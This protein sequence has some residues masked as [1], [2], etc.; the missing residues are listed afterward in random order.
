MSTTVAL[1]KKIVSTFHHRIS[2]WI[3]PVMPAHTHKLSLLRA[4]TRSSN[5]WPLGSSSSPPACSCRSS[6]GR[7]E[8]TEHGTRRST[9]LSS[10]AEGA[11]SAHVPHMTGR[12][13]SRSG[14]HLHTPT[15]RCLRA[16]FPRIP[17]TA[18]LPH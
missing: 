9:L 6:Q 3:T 18:L 16:L 15:R 4:P 5:G 17:R 13:P 8:P 12:W 10:G 14:R 11:P 7:Q 1:P 2:P